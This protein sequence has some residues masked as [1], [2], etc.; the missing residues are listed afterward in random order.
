MLCSRRFP[1][2]VC[3]FAL[4]TMLVGLQVPVARAQ[5]TDDD[6]HIKP[7]IELKPASDTANIKELEAGFSPHTKPLKASAELVLVPVTITDPMNRLV[8]GLDR[9]NFTVFEGKSQQEIRS[10][11]SEDA[12]VSLGVIFDMSG[13]MSRRSTEPAKPWW[14]FSRRRILG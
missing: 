9:E 11:S 6:V 13:S 3:L 1:L 10:F 7:R 4:L 5:N 2:Y 8:T 12:P 14:S